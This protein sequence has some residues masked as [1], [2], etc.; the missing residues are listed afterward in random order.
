MKAVLRYKSF[1]PHRRDTWY[2]N[3]PRILLL[4]AIF[5]SWAPFYVSI[6][7]TLR[8]GPYPFEWFDR[9]PIIVGVI[10]LFSIPARPIL[11][12]VALTIL[13]S[14]EVRKDW[15]RRNRFFFYLVATLTITLGVTAFDYCEGLWDLA[16]S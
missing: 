5:F 12:L 15:P 9:Q 13:I 16:G 2:E 7:E 3:W 8:P 10:W 1:P 11:F 6:A 4:L 14:S